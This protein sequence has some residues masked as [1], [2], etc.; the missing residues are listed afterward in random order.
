[1]ALRLSMRQKRSYPMKLFLFTTE[2]RQNLYYKRKSPRITYRER[3]PLS[4]V[5]HL[6]IWRFRLY[7]EKQKRL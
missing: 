4:R 5:V 7:K 1:M 6:E 3:F 2:V